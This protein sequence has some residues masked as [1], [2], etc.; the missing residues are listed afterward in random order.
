MNRRDRHR[1]HAQRVHYQRTHRNR[2]RK[3]R[4]TLDSLDGLSKQA[5]LDFAAE[6]KIHV[7]KSWKKD[8]LVDAIRD[9]LLTE[10]V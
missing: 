7:M 4:E 5:L 3:I 2:R 6:K 10:A 1:K 8:K 9:S